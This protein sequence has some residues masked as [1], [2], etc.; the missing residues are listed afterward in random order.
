MQLF[1]FLTNEHTCGYKKVKS[2]KN[3]TQDPQSLIVLIEMSCLT[4]INYKKMPFSQYLN[5][6]HAS[7]CINCGG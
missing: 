4:N 5:S 2:K 3:G 7:K 1:S 6:N